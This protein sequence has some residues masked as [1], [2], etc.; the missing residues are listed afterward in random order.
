MMTRMPHTRARRGFTLI[1]MMV[2]LAILA[3]IGAVLYR[4]M[5]TSFSAKA[6]VSEVNDRYHEGRQVMNRI[7]RELRMAFLLFEVPEQMREENPAVLTR[8]QG[9]EDTI[10]FATTAHLRLQANA[11]ESDQAEIG[12]FLKRSD[13]DSD[14]RGKTLFRRES[15]RV[16]DRFD[17]GGTI[18]PVVDGVKEFKLE[19]W[20]ETKAI[21]DDAWQSSWDTESDDND[22]LPSRVRITL[23]LDSGDERPDIRFVAQAAPRVR[24]PIAVIDRFVP[25]RAVRNA[26]QEEIDKRAGDN[27]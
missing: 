18:W 21:G 5:S 11:R 1:E 10:H 27:P 24:R 16:D 26:M 14:Y 15:R 13:R 4:S 7:T 6:W 17:K 22:L 2:S 20:D 8:F 3:S 19:Y 12:Y 9:E 25:Q 23:V